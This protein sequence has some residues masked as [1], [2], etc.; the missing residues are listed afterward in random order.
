MM[1]KPIRL[2]LIEDDQEDVLLIRELLSDIGGQS[3]LLKYAGELEAGLEMAAAGEVDIVLLDLSLPDSQGLETFIRLYGEIPGVPIVVMSGLNDERIALTAVREGAQDYLVKGHVDHNILAR[4]IRYAIERK[5][6]EEEL[7]LSLEKLRRSLEKTISAMSLA[8]EI[9]DPYTAGHQREV[10]KL[11]EAIGREMGLEKEQLDGVR[12]AAEVHDLGKINI[13][14]EILS[15]PGPLTPIEFNLIQTHPKVGFDILKSIEF[16]WP[17][18]RIVHQ[19]HERINGSGYPE[20]LTGSEILLEAKI[21]SVA[22]VV[23]AMSSH[24]PYRPALG[25]EKALNE[26]VLHRGTLYDADVV[27]VCIKLFRE[28]KF[29]FGNS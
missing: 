11:V 3:F 4:T 19:H 5:R 16:P 6:V 15:K 14:A 22:D 29:R 2:L 28:R 25:V 13:P 24:R 17:I 26:I 8:V 18:D 20:G 1:E 21:L 9:R 23:E 12:L 27:D 7:R 10:T